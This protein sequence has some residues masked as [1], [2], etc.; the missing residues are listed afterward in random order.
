MAGDSIDFYVELLDALDTQ[1]SCDACWMALSSEERRRAGR[2]AFDR[3]RRQYVFA[4]GLVRFALSGL[5]PEIEPADWAFTTDHHG[6]PFVANPTIS[7]PVYFSLSHTEGC[8]ACAI[9]GHSAIGID[10][11]RIQS[12]PSLMET[13]QSV[14]SSDEIEALRGLG[15]DQF[16]DRFFDYWTLKEAYLK[17]NGSGL[18]VPLDQF[19]ML[20]ASGGIAIR[21]AQGI[22]DDP[23]R[24]RFTMTSPS[25]IH[26]LA[27]ADGSGAPGG[28]PVIPRSSPLPRGPMPG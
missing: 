26:R 10:V 28:L 6:R 12:R 20:L 22:H 16:V 3:H 25:S 23:R 13:A 1:Q 4:H 9:S 18:S 5:L 14:L 27:I 2:F 21:F 11:E 17:A 8:V 7:R 24:W 15:P 19:S